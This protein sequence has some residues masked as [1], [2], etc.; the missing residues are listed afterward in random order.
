M[1]TTRTILLFL[2]S[3]LAGC[4]PDSS[5]GE[6]AETALGNSTRNVPADH[7]VHLMSSQLV[8]D[9]KSLGVPFSRPDSAYVYAAAYFESVRSSSSSGTDSTRALLVPMAHLYGRQGFR[10]ALELSEEREYTAVRREND[11]VAAEAARRPDRAAALCGV[12]F[13]RPY[14]WAEIHRCREELGSAG[15]KLHLASAEADLKDESQLDE[16]ARIAGWAEKEGALLLL[17]F[18]PQRR[19]LETDDVEHFITRVLEPHPDLQICIAHLG[20]SG[21][22][23]SW[24]RSVLHT[25]AGWLDARASEGDSRPGVW[26][27]LSGV[28]L[29]E[30][31]EGIP[32]SQ[33][34]HGRALGE[35][36]GGALLERV[37]FGSD[38]PV[39]QPGTYAAQLQAATGIDSV[40]WNR[41]LRNRLPV[42]D[43]R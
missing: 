21:G 40:S 11:H 20:G 25:F 26:F 27:D 15:I 9:W 31:S 39:F 29:E 10:E 32:A 22:Y 2:L 16:L 13:R 7:H 28:W 35:D 41:I 38:Y 30:S 4:T 37:V 42:L 24:T 33:P 8:A 1:K 14:A 34:A 36:L 19:G 5:S 17:H 23:G 3:A 12:D 6:S 18:D 43:E